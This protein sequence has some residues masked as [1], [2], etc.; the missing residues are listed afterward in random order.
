MQGDWLAHL[1]M[2]YAAG[3]YPGGVALIIFRCQPLNRSRS[4]E[5]EW[6]AVVFDLLWDIYSALQ[7][8]YLT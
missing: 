4:Y 7:T 8:V 2:Q 3:V 6:N 5:A 1:Q